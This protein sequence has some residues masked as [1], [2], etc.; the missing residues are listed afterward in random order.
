MPAEEHEEIILT[1]PDGSL[2]GPGE[3][4][5]WLAAVNAEPRFT[6]EQRDLA[7]AIVARIRALSN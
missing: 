5:E 3:L 7:F 6:Q 2:V 4:S 1:F